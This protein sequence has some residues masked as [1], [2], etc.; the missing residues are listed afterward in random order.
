[1]CT[2]HKANRLSTMQASHAVSKRL[3][4]VRRPGS[5]SIAGELTRILCYRLSSHLPAPRA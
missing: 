1:M 4:T 3:D 5:H 2:M